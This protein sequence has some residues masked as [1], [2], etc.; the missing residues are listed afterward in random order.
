V[1]EV[2]K[3]LRKRSVLSEKGEDSW[4]RS[5]AKR[6][7]RPRSDTSPILVQPLTAE[8]A[9]KDADEQL[10]YALKT[11]R[12]LTEIGVKEPR[13]ALWLPNAENKLITDAN[14]ATPDS[15]PAVRTDTPEGLAIWLSKLVR[16]T[17]PNA[18]VLQIET[19]GY[20]ENSVP[21]AVTTQL[22]EDLQQ[23]FS[24][25]VNCEVIPD[26]IW[27]FWGEEINEQVRILPGNRVIIAVHDLDITPSADKGTI[28]TSLE[29]KLSLAQ[30]A[31][32]QVNKE[33]AGTRKV[34][35][36]FTALL[37]KNAK[38]LPF[39]SYP[40]NG[41]F[42]NWQLLRFE[43]SCDQSGMKPLPASLA[44]FRGQLN[45]WAANRTAVGVA[46]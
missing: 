46:A 33:S 44:V 39:A 12:A 8:E 1:D 17:T 31:V 7:L 25:I 27:K 22:A 16:K 23:R 29:M 4:R 14:S 40:S 9:G 10:A 30:D 45:K 2:D 26:P 11:T 21:D 15:F 18:V 34:D 35:P 37:V 5:T 13:L 3:Q 32:E 20:S 24:G 19:I 28:R 36:F 42:K 41:R 38:A 43:P 6:F